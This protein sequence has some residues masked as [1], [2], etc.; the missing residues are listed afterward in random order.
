MRLH[1][2]GSSRVGFLHATER[3]FREV[4]AS[5]FSATRRTDLS[6]GDGR[7]LF[8]CR[9]VKIR[10]LDSVANFYIVIWHARSFLGKKSYRGR[11]ETLPVPLREMFQTEGAKGWRR[12]VSY[13]WA[14]CLHQGTYDIRIV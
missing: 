3:M 11:A 7:S 9:N 6:Q 13:R 5:T 10:R 2:R 14:K 1:A 8:V 4:F 12:T